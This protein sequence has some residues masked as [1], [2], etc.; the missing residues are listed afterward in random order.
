VVEKVEGGQTVGLHAD[1]AVLSDP[2]AL[3]KARQDVRAASANNATSLVEYRSSG[4]CLVVAATSDADARDQALAC[5]ASL[6]DLSVT[7]LCPLDDST[8]GD[9]ADRQITDAGIKVFYRHLL[10]ID[11]HLGHFDV[12]VATASATPDDAPE[13][14]GVTALTESGMFDLVLD[15]GSDA[16]DALAPDERQPTRSARLPPFGYYRAPDQASLDAALVELPQMVGEFEKP[17]YFQYDASICAHSRSKLPGCTNC[18]DV[19][20][21]QAIQ[22]DGEGVRIDPYLCQGCGHCASVCPSGA[23]VYAFPSAAEAISRSRELLGQ[24]DRGAGI[25]LL[26]AVAEDADTTDSVLAEFESGLPDHVLALAVEE[27]GAYGM[28][29]WATMLASGVNRV[30]VLLEPVGRAASD[31]PAVLVDGP[32]KEA[33]VAQAGILGAM[34][35]GIGLPA[36]SVQVIDSA[37]DAAFAASLAEPATKPTYP[38]AT[39]ATHNDKRQTVRQA[40]DHMAGHL[41][42][43]E[44]IVELPADSPFGVINIRATDCTLCMA[45]VTTC[46]AGALL[47]GHSVPQL[48]FV[49]ANCVQCGLCEQACPENV[50]ERQPRYLFD[51]VKAREH[52]ILNEEEPFNCLRCHKPFGTRK[53][54][55]TLTGKLG[56]HWMYG[57]ESAI[58]RLKMCEDCRVKDMFEESDE[59]I[60]VHKTAGIE[61]QGQ[62]ADKKTGPSG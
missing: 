36:D 7:V 55:E 34:L 22:T 9:T 24:R 33:L 11:G 53:M 17:K 58:R 38:N 42:V 16:R 2:D 54:I 1:I 23:M 57:N 56:D 20:S 43:N 12:Q 8:A 47:D 62:P 32:A 40:I 51:S 10:G 14:L 25:L 18:I 60:E 50:L 21:T 30:V 35:S 4:Q 29:Y 46:P 37:H 52:V 6:S 13:H 5:A 48:K 45:C 28:D 15:L 3:L 49:E 39:F 27:P 59:G 41:S 31:E 26:H 44:P 61:T 19:C